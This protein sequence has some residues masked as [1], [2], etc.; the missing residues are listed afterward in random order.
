MRKFTSIDETNQTISILQQKPEIDQKI[1]YY[2]SVLKSTAELIESIGD[3][4]KLGYTIEKYRILGISIVKRVILDTYDIATL[5]I[6]KLESE[7]KLFAQKNYFEMWLSRSRDYEVKFDEITRECNLNYDKMFEEAY[8]IKENIRLQTTMAKFSNP[9]NDQRIKNE[10][11]LF[12]K[13]EVENAAQYG[14]RKSA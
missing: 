10:F 11:Y 2:K 4:I 5:E 13:Q 6:E 8:S 9:D 14:R 7:A 1:S 12:L 3:R